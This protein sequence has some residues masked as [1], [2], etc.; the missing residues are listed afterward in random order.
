[1]I[2]SLCGR[3]NRYMTCRDPLSAW[4]GGAVRKGAAG[5]DDP[6]EHSF[7]VLRHTG[8]VIEISH[9]GG[10]H[11]VLHRRSPDELAGIW[12][13]GAGETG[14]EIWRRE[15]PPRIERITCRHGP[16]VT[17]SSVGGPPCRVTVKGQPS[18]RAMRGNLPGLQFD[19][20]GTG[21][22]GAGPLPLY[23][24]YGRTKIEIDRYC[25]LYAETF[26]GEPHGCASWGNPSAH[27]G[28]IIG[29][30][31]KLN[32]THGATSGTKRF[33]LAGQPVAFD[34]SIPPP[35]AG[36]DA[37]LFRIETVGDAS[38]YQTLTQVAPGQRFRVRLVY[39]RTPDTDAEP[40]TV[41]DPANGGDVTV[42][43]YPTDNPI[44]FM[45][46]PITAGEPVGEA[47]PK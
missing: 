32:V 14:A 45:T 40:V 3:S 8:E 25:Y 27:Y 46:D 47:V 39:R 5:T 34:L 26:G 41:R 16:V 6:V 12:T 20:F 11:S 29:L 4:T 24:N 15:P 7:N 38:P 19:I 31:V 17:E 22:G 18:F 21:I 43:A 23:M 1:M 28:P 13:N 33:W 30:R 42:M 35:S 9:W 2:D 10:Y 37:E 36:E 44:I